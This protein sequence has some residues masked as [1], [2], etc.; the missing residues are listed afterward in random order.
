MLASSIA[1]YREQ[2]AQEEGVGK[3]SK[4]VASG[5]RDLDHKH[6]GSMFTCTS[7]YTPYMCP[8]FIYTV[9]EAGMYLIE[10]AL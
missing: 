9:S 4:D 6:P 5:E 3:L 8:V 7:I 10:Q 1:S 2:S